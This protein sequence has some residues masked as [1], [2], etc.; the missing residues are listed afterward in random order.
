MKGTEQISLNLSQ[1]RKGR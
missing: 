1:L